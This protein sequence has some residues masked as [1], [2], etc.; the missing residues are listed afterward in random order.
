ME[1]GLGRVLVI[2][3]DE[4]LGKM[5]RRVLAPEHDVLVLASAREALDR[6][7]DGERFDLVLCDLMLPGVT[8]IDFYECLGAS[9]PELVERVVFLTGGAYSPRSQ[10]FLER[11]TIPWIQKPLPPLTEF[12]ALVREH[13]AR[14]GK[15][16]AH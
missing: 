2:E 16:R 13:L 15:G 5:L 7:C 1:Q 6:I 3:D 4:L 12:R 11:A 14:A 10:A 9:A 8:G